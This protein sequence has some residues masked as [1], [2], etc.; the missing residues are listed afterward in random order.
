MNVILRE[1]IE[2]V[3]RAG[4]IVTVKDGYARNFL[5]PRGLAVAATTG[6][7]RQVAAERERRA[8]RH[9]AD[10]TSA[11][12]LAQQ[13]GDVSLTFTMKAGEGEKLFGSITAADIAAKLIELGHEIDK[14]RVELAEPI[15]L[16][17]IYKV[18]VRLDAGVHAE[19]RVWVVKE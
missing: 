6:N 12:G 19:V 3:G 13:L 14:R 8:A 10:R 5:I 9:A 17:G 4:E 15:K 2:H 7:Q 11:E 16:V 18:P 1:D